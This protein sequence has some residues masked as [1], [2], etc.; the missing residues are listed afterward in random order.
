MLFAQHSPNAALLSFF[1]FISKNEALLLYK[2][3]YILYIRNTRRNECQKCLN[4][5]KH[6]VWPPLVHYICDALR[7][8]FVFFL[9]INIANT[10]ITII[11]CDNDNNNNPFVSTH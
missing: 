1:I 11:L 9:I 3:K 10:I 8:C 5:F 6:Y 7:M 2:Y 4:Y